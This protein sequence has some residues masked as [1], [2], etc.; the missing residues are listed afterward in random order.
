MCG[1]YVFECGCV[2]RMYSTYQSYTLKGNWVS[3]SWQLWIARSSIDGNG[4][5]S[6]PPSP[7][8]LG[9]SFVLWLH[10]LVCAATSIV[11][12]HLGLPFC[13]WKTQFLVIFLLPLSL[14]V[15]SIPFLKW[16][17]RLRR[18]RRR[19]IDA[20]FRAE[21]SAVSY[22]QH[23]GQLLVFEVITIYCNK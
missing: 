12:S 20:P 14:A 1:P 15:F 8:M 16:C 2:A 21:H 7:S 18:R 3:L 19:H 22:S 5:F 11:N 17:L 9:F 6:L 23:L 10:S 4:L 13:I